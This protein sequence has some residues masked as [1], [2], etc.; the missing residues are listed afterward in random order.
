[1]LNLC[2]NQRRTRRPLGIASLALATWTLSGCAF[3]ED[4]DVTPSWDIICMNCS[5]SEDLR[6]GATDTLYVHSTVDG[7]LRVEVSNPAVA[8]WEPEWSDG[9][10]CPEGSLNERQDIHMTGLA[11][12][13]TTISFYD[14]DNELRGSGVV[15]IA[16]PS[17]VL[18]RAADTDALV[19]RIELPSDY[20]S[21]DFHLE[22]FGTDGLELV[23]EDGVQCEADDERVSAHYVG[24]RLAVEGHRRVESTTLRCTT[25]GLSFEYPVVF[26]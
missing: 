15:R 12:G 11:A 6:E 8:S 24:R 7:C 22:F 1:M 4:D 14:R 13:E 18:L 9:P 10:S 3:A 17:D 23:G 5:V 19:N 26:R 20:P 16:K 2:K 21:A 25:T